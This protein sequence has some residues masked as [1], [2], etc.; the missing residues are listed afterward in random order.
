MSD[1]KPSIV[2]GSAMDGN[3]SAQRQ[4]D[5]ER[6]DNQAHQGDL[7]RGA[8]QAHQPTEYEQTL[9]TLR[10][11]AGEA[12]PNQVNDGD[13]IYEYLRQNHGV[14]VAQMYSRICVLE[15]RVAELEEHAE[16]SIPDQEQTQTERD[17]RCV[18]S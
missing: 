16:N 10:E 6:G 11:A 7:E 14:I 9:Q 3:G 17:Q 13:L 15:S 8:N 12:Y 1:I 18:Q 2:S 4:G 5:L